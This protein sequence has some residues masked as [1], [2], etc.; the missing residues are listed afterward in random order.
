M[1]GRG[2]Q[3]KLLFACDTRKEPA[4]FIISNGARISIISVDLQ[5]R[6]LSQDVALFVKIY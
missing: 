2:K 4:M 3:N 1:E 5:S 6:D